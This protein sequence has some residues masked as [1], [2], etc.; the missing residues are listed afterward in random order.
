MSVIPHVKT[1]YLLTSLILF[2]AACSRLAADQGPP[3]PISTYF[4][5]ATG[6]VDATVEEITQEGAARIK[7]HQVL[8]GSDDAPA[9][10]PGFTTDTLNLVPASRDLEI[11]K[12]YIL[13][14]RG[15]LLANYGFHRLHAFEVREG[16]GGKLEAFYTGFEPDKNG[17]YSFSSSMKQFWEPLETFKARITTA[18]KEKKKE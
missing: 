6:I 7:I 5:S 9:V 4:I 10:I 18:L 11:R 15:N 14:L 12:R 8:K 16:E 2:V 1:T 3:A 13:L 17:K